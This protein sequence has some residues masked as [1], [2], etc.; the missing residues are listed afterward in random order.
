[1]KVHAD[2][3]VPPSVALT[4]AI[5]AAWVAERLWVAPFLPP[6]LPRW[7]LGGVLIAAAL[8]HPADEADRRTPIN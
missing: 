1:V 5:G 2:G 7:A 3:L 8:L 6:S 4:L